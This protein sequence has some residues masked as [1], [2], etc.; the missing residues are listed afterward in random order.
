MQ[1]ND[2]EVLLTKTGPTSVFKLNGFG[3]LAKRLFASVSGAVTWHR[4]NWITAGP[5]AAPMERAP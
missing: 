5:V 1:A 2:L 4:V 3:K